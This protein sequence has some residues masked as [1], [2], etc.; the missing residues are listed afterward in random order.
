M[1]RIM[2]LIF[3]IMLLCTSSCFAW[4]QY[5]VFDPF[6]LDAMVKE[7]N[8]SNTF[9]GDLKI[10]KMK[11]NNNR[12]YECLMS[13][14]KSLIVFNKYGD[15]LISLGVFADGNNYQQPI[16]TLYSIFERVGISNRNDFWAALKKSYETKKGQ[17]FAVRKSVEGNQIYYSV[18]AKNYKNYLFVGIS[19]WITK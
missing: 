15:F 1:K 4:S 12:E 19:C 10:I 9:N 5:A 2:G 17:P 11:L 7:I 8:S 13:D 3:S 18:E 6:D 14:N 16:N